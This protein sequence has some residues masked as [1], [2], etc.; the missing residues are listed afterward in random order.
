L[1]HDLDFWKDGVQ[2]L[3]SDRKIAASLLYD[4]SV[5][6]RFTVGSNEVV[7]KKT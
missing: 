5:V 1:C 7:E 6:F 4:V 2:I 3:T